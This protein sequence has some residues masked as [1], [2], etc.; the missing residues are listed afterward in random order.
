[1]IEMD[2]IAEYIQQ[3]SPRS[4]LRFLEAI[5]KTVER[6]LMFPELGAHFETGIPE[7]SDLRVNLVTGFEKYLLFYRVRSEEVHIER[8]VLGSRDLPNILRE[9]I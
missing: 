6:L 2:A 1:M 7:L 9:G 5:E 3:S 8:V 4:A